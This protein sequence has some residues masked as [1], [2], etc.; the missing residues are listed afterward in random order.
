M[1][2]PDGGSNRGR[3]RRQRRAK[4]AHHILRYVISAAQV[5]ENGTRMP[6]SR[7]TGG[8]GRCRCGGAARSL[9][10][11]GGGMCVETVA[12]SEGCR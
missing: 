11:R 12:D 1:I 10:S 4:P 3:D 8:R 5:T 9:R 6:A 7:F 2:K